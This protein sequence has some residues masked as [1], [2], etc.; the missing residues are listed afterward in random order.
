MTSLNDLDIHVIRIGIEFGIE[1]Y[2]N[3]VHLAVV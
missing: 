3:H 2:A 1:L